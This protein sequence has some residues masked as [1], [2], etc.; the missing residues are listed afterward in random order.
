[1]GSI[2]MRNDD[3]VPAHVRYELLLRAR[4][5]EA[6]GFLS[7]S[8]GK[9]AVFYGVLLLFALF[10]MLGGTD[11]GRRAAK[12]VR[13]S[14]PATLHPADGAPP[15]PVP[16]AA[17][18]SRPAIRVDARHMTPY[19]VRD[20]MRSAVDFVKERQDFAVE[21][22][23]RWLSGTTTTRPGEL[24][25]K[26]SIPNAI[27]LPYADMLAQ[28]EAFR[29]A[30]VK[31]SGRLLEESLYKWTWK[32]PFGEERDLMFGI[33]VTD[34]DATGVQFLSLEPIPEHDPRLNTRWEA[35]GVFVQMIRQEVKGGLVRDL[36]LLVLTN[37]R[38]APAESASETASK[39]AQARV[40]NLRILPARA[41]EGPMSYVSRLGI[42]AGLGGVLIVMFFILRRRLAEPPASRRPRPTVPKKQD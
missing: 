39:P 2:G 25:S 34:A 5:R 38:S 21:P 11:M 1:M 42:L 8:I 10:A 3:K 33:V 35:E 18:Q 20:A 14:K 9:R 36:P 32:D 16:T 6:P 41:V 40:G 22:V 13:R 17:P 37:S 7:S 4:K 15:P 12:A 24:A 30:F 27:E 26:D 19:S 31:T 23:L 28:P 29:G